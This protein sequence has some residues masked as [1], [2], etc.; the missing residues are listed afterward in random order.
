[1]ALVNDDILLV[2]LAYAEDL[3]VA[4]NGDLDVVSGLNNVSA[5]LLRR[6]L[7][8]PGT[9]AHAPDYGA[10]LLSFQGAPMTLSQKQ[11]IV[12]KIAE[13]LP[14]DPRV[15]SISS[16]GIEIPNNNPAQMIITLK[17]KI[18]GLGEQQITYTPFDGGAV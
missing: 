14:L 6:I 4:P 17:V 11:K 12:Q 10:G 5:A 7:T 2:D 15:E 1:M 8:I 3:S 13:Q 9:L 16:V 18:V